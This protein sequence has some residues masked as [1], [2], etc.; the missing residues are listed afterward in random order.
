M[1][2][3]EIPKKTQKTTTGHEIPIPKRSAFINELARVTK[4]TAPTVTKPQ[5]KPL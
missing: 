1:G 2:K 3:K 4:K 5:K